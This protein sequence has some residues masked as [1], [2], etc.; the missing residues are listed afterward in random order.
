MCPGFTPI[1]QIPVH[2]VSCRVLAFLLWFDDECRTAKRV[3]RLSERAARRPGLLSDAS[4]AAAASYHSQGHRYV[5]LL[6]QKESTFWSKRIDAQQSQP[7][8]LWR[9]LLNCLA[10][11]KILCHLTLMHLPSVSS[12]TTR[13]PVFGQL[14]CALMNLGSHQ[15]RS[16]VSSVSVT[17]TE[18][19]EM[20]LA[21]PD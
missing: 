21:L 11:A 13:L 14:L 12:S 16:G 15:P 17:Q 18:I 2:R 5:T 1:Q 6:R 19:I 7:R 3:L 10:E 20:V 9:S 8:Q 4:S